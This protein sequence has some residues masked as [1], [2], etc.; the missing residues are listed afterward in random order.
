LRELSLIL[1]SITKEITWWAFQK[2]E[3]LVIR[4]RLLQ[5]L[6]KL[7]P[8]RLSL[9]REVRA[10][11]FK[12]HL[13]WL[14]SI[15]YDSVSALFFLIPRSVRKIM[16]MLSS[17]WQYVLYP[18]QNSFCF[19]CWNVASIRIVYPLDWII[20]FFSTIFGLCMPSNVLCI[21]SLHM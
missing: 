19:P 1:W 16:G 3:V 6:S 12:Y 9:A 11:F 5:K 14:L 13:T 7:Q 10:K 4:N 8:I 2:V 18:H 20:L 17:L 21:V 15:A